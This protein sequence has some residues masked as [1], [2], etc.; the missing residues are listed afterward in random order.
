[1]D[2]FATLFSIAQIVKKYVFQRHS[3]TTRNGGLPPQYIVRS[4]EK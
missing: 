3:E 2:A 4:G 1:M